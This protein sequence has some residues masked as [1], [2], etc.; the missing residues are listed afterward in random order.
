M[1]ERKPPINAGKYRHR[2]VICAAPDDAQRNDYGERTGSG[3]VVAEVYA[4]KEDWG[5]RELA[6][7]GHE[8]AELSTRFKIRY[9]LGVMA[10]MVV[11]CEGLDYAIDGPP[12]DFD[13]TRR[14]LVLVCRRVKHAGAT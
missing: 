5:A 4:A 8:V 13:G 6:E 3:P 10:G 12:M 2:L 7:L 11:R 14:E 9:R 1:A